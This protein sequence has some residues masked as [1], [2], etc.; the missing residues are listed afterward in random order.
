MSQSAA[1]GHW[2]NRLSIASRFLIIGLAGPILTLNFWAFATI[3]KFFG[4]LVAV[5]VLASL[6]AFLLNY[7]VRWMEEQGNPRGLSHFRLSASLGTDCH[8]WLGG[9]TQCL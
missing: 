7:P 2:W 3:L 9:G 4:P 6:F 8:Y 5:L 1:S